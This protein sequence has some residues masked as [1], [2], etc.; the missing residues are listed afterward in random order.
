M[1]ILEPDRKQ[2]ERMVDSLFRHATVD[3]F[4]SLRTFLDEDKDEV[5][6]IFGAKITPDRRHL[7]DMAEARARM[8]ANDPQKCVFCPPIATFN[9]PKQ[10]REIDLVDGLALSV[11]CD[12]RPTDA[13]AKLEELLGPATIA[14]HS[15]GV[16][17]DPNTGE[18]HQKVHLHWRLARPAKGEDL[19]LL[20]TART[21]A[22]AIVG[23]DPSN[24]P[25]V[26]PIRWPGSWHRKANPVMCT[27]AAA[28]PDNEIDLIK[29]LP[30]LQKA[31]QQTDKTYPSLGLDDEWKRPDDYVKLINK[32]QSGEAYHQPLVSLSARFIASGMSDRSVDGFLRDLMNASVGPR[33]DRWQARFDGIGRIVE[34]AREKF[35][36]P[37]VD[38]PSIVPSDTPL[39]DPWQRYVVPKFP[40]DLLPFAVRLFVT[41]QAEIIGADPSALAMTAMASLSGAISHR[42]ALKLMK[43]GNWWASPRLCVLL[44]GDPSTKKTPMINACTGEL[45]RQQTS[46]WKRWKADLNE[47]EAAGGDP[48]KFRD[49]PPRYTAYDITVEK[50]GAI[51]AKQDRGILVKRDELAGWIGS[52]EKYTSGRGASADRA[53]WLKAFDG[54]PFTVDRISRGELFIDNLSAS[55]IGGIQPARLAE[56]TGLTSDG[57]LQRFLPCMI[58]G[59][60]FPKD[61]E[62]NV[63]SERFAKLLQA[64]LKRSPQKLILDSDAVAAMEVLRRHLHEIEQE[65]GGLPSGFQ[66]F[67]GKLPG[68]AGSLALIL[69][70]AEDPDRQAGHYSVDVDVVVDVDLLMRDFILPHAL[71]FYRSMERASGGDKLQRLASWILTSS[72]NRIMPSDLT[73]NVA[74]MRGLGLWD[75]NQRLSPLVAGGWLAPCERGPVCKA[76][77]V[78]PAVHEFFRGRA[79]AEKDRKVAVAELMNSPRAR[80]EGKS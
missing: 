27:I 56:I 69:D 30:V 60:A 21:L 74:D 2:I 78:N 61:V 54:G 37:A 40:V 79:R 10:A 57:L 80:K 26:H 6:G 51:L 15:G 59:A 9:N 47:Y 71:E 24:K 13:K 36:R 16:W 39:F 72:K 58:S 75:V 64:L 4:A 35:S 67:V 18:I 14:V 68:V 43:N 46:D 23:G 44:V 11:E 52:M 29:A 25:I 28:N 73:S 33:D 48:E 62:D 12:Q 31:A 45:D 34:S 53:F 41:R 17:A 3:T 22:T 1:I 76:W 32:I 5:K 55:I 63:D 66:S 65:S 20:K 77:M 7:V 50:L 38:A 70:L 42:H 19:K 49:P 8:A